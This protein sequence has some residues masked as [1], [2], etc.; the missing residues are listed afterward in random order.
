MSLQDEPRIERR[1]MR[2]LSIPVICWR[3]DAPMKVK[4]V[5]PAMT[6]PS[7]D[8]I[9]YSCPGC[10]DERMQIVPTD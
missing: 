9:V 6:F 4:T 1:K 2:F 8:E 5:I 7:R 10:H 3:C